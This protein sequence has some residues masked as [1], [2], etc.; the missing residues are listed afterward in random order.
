MQSCICRPHAVETPALTFT[1]HQ[2]YDDGGAGDA[3]GGA[4][5]ADRADG[6][7]GAIEGGGAAEDDWRDDDG[8]VIDLCS[9]D[10]P[11]QWEEGAADDYR[12][13]ALMAPPLGMAGGD[14]DDDGDD[15]ATGGWGHDA[16]AP[17]P[18]R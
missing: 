7:G 10:G 13:D 4:G 3:D 6:D 14:D 11:S 2:P 12:H 9:D 1:R 17:E 15:P 8:G 18:A 16:R 5:D